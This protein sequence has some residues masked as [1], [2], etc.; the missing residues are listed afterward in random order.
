MADKRFWSDQLIKE[1]I[2][3]FLEI[4]EYRKS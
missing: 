4:I 3:A 1:N 2:D